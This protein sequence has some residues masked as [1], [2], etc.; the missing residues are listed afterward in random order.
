M[1]DTSVNRFILEVLEEET[2][3][4]TAHEI[5]SKLRERLPCVNQSTVYRALERL[6]ANGIISVSDLGTGAAVFE[7]VTN[8]M[9]HH[10]VCQKCGQILTLDKKDVDQFFSTINQK[11]R[12]QI[13]TNHLVLFGICPDCQ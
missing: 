8:A 1:K 10:M 9:H 2:S 7:K 3:H 12:Y 13:I 6:A 11:T 4:L 5:Y